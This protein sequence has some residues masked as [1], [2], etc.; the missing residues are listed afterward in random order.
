M[1]VHWPAMDR[2]VAITGV[3]FH[4]FQNFVRYLMDHVYI[5]CLVQGNMTKEDVIKNV[6]ECVKTLKCGPLLPNTL[7]Q[8]RVAQIPVGSHYCKVRNFNGTDVNSVVMNYYQ[9]GVASVRLSVI[10]ELL[11]VSRGSLLTQARPRV[12][13]E[14]GVSK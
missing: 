3:E 4:E 8:I 13:T 5:Q 2:H 10:I 12:A 7:P 6:H 11:I 1:L 14:G 9:S